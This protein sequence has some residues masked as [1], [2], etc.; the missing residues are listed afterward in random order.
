[1]KDQI[2][3]LEEEKLSII[4][5]STAKIAKPV[6]LIVFTKNAAPEVCP[7]VLALA[8]A[9]KGKMET[10]GVEAYD[11]VMDK[12][13]TELYGIQRVPALVVLGVTGRSVVFYGSTGKM[14]LEI[15]LDTV[16][17][18]SDAKVWFPD[19]IRHSLKRL[20]GHV[21]VHIFVNQD[22][23]LCRSIAETAVGLALENEQIRTAI[24]NADEF[25]DL[26]KKNNIGVFP[27]TI[28]GNNLQVHG[29]I[30]EGDFLEKIFLVEGAESEPNKKCL[31]CGN[32]S[33]DIICSHCKIRI[34]AEAL[35]HK[36]SIEKQKKS[37]AR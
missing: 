7:A 4:R 2:A 11:L 33:P 21:Q 29:D 28:F 31:S 22:N 30:S 24:I 10:I 26:V 36:R 3:M 17:H 34:Q 25:P 6:K 8:R 13:Q 18:V 20:T 5:S 15:L 35:D 19:G 37:T 9:V 12:D 14:F 32:A 16:Q 1:M 23:A 27:T